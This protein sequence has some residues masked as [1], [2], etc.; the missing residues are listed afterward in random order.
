MDDLNLDTADNLRDVILTAQTYLDDAGVWFGHGTDNALDE[1]AWLVSHALG[2]TPDFA[3]ESLSHSL[4]EAEKVSVCA[5]L[6]RRVEERLPAAYLT[7]RAWFAGLPFSVDERVLVPR[8][9]IAELI[10]SEFRPWLV[11][12]R[13]ERVLDLCTGSACIAIATACALPQAQVDASD[14]SGAALDVARRNIGE[15]NLQDRVHLFESDL[16]SALGGQR[17]DLI[18]SNPPYVDAEDMAALPEEYRREPELGLMAGSRGLDLVIPMLRDAP[19]YL[20]PEGLIIVEV[21]NSAEALSQQFPQ[22]PF[23][24]LDFEYGGEGIFLLEARQLSDYHT[25]FAEAATRL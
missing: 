4:S 5:L 6:R 2:L 15:H 12:D 14:I 18:V 20:Q 23:T 11:P 7:G 19:G 3:E 13:V 9:P 22:V 25:D 1:A 8:S 17:Y 24:W 21:G 10:A 16:F